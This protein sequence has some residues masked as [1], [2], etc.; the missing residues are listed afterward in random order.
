MRYLPQVDLEDLDMTPEAFEQ[1]IARILGILHLSDSRVE[2]NAR[3][4]DPD[5]ADQ[6]RQIDVSIRRPDSFTIVE[7]R[8]HRRPQDVKWI[9]EL[10][11]RRISL[12]AD[13]AIAVSS[14]GFTHGAVRKAKALG[15][16][17]RV[18]SVVTDAEVQRWG[19]RTAVRIRYVK[20]SRIQLAIVVSDL[21]QVPTRPDML[22]TTE[23]EPFPMELALHA[24]SN[25]VL[26]G[27]PEGRIALELKLTRIWLGML[28]VKEA[29]VSADWIG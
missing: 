20:L 25:Q 17:T 16:F 11:G 13:A 10:A 27:Q 9:E 2:W 1:Q 8:L 23:G 7:C 5:N 3:I 29:I 26:D 14:S 12:R 15:I 6:L 4:P 19:Q 28:P 21:I 24:L 22:R 18:L